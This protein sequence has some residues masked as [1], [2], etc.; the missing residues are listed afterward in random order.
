MGEK[1]K[2]KISIERLI[3]FFLKLKSKRPDPVETDYS[4]W[5]QSEEA[6]QQ[7]QA[8]WLEEIRRKKQNKNRG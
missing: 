4:R 3:S 7:E 5:N 2:N 6:Y 8:Q 1:N